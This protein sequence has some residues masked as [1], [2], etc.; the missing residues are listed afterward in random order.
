MHAIF[1]ARRKT[2]LKVLS[3]ARVSP[4]L[5]RQLANKFGCHVSAIRSDIQSLSVEERF[6]GSVTPI[7]VTPLTRK[8]VRERDG[9]VCQYCGCPTGNKRVV[10]HVVPSFRGG[11][12][13]AYNLVIACY[14]CNR[15]K[16]N[17]VWIPR[18]LESITV[19]NLEWRRLI[20]EL[21]T[22]MQEE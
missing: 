19:E 15:A 1:R 17:R 4:E 6:G 8:I 18:N 5:R 11:I 20:E 10:E 3:L 9:K 14:Q 2:V 16:S 7:Y 21:A 12:S 13:K 22:S